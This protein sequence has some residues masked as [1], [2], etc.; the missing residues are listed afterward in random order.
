MPC[1][2]LPAA[3]SGESAAEFQKRVLQEG[4]RKFQAAMWQVHR[5]MEA[6]PCWQRMS[7]AQQNLNMRVRL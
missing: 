4:P 1:R 5:A 7:E 2:A 3:A 6:L